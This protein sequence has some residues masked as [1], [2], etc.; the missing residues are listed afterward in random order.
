[1][2]KQ[3]I[4]TKI[5]LQGW[6]GANPGKLEEI[7]EQADIETERPDRNLPTLVRK[8]LEAF[9]GRLGDE[10]FKPTLAEYL[11]LLQFEQEVTNE[12]K[13]PREITVTWVEPEA[14]YSEE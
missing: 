6:R 8:A 12:D 11:K 1:M 7:D 3:N 5:S 4:K 9:E 2:E 10:N 13:L 14:D